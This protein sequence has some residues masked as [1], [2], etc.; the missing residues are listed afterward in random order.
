MNQPNNSS[1][2]YYLFF[3]TETT[4]LPKDYKAPS[5]A[6]NNWP[7]MIQLSWITTDIDGTIISENDH[8]IYPDGF[9]IP[10]TASAVNG[11]TMDVARTKGDLIKD[12][13]GLF[14]ADV[15]NAD[16]VVGHNVSFDIHVVGAE[17]IR[18]G[19]RDTI[20]LK[21]SICTM[22][23]SID[24]CAI[25]GYYGYKYP[26]LQELHK[27]LFNYEFEDAHN[28]LS[29]IRATLKCFFELKEREIIKN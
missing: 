9:I 13:L 3:D 24:F 14:L 22:E 16:Y 12:V 6:I 11:I 18:Q 7:R 28:A 29:D 5:S 26:S 19:K 17:L 4:G 8:I 20:A 1:K 10:Q 27:K 15:E 25:P 21:P 23:S 2:E